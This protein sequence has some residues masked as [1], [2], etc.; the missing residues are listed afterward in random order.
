[1]RTPV[2]TPIQERSLSSLDSGREVSR[3][4]DDLRAM[5]V[6]KIA[7]GSKIAGGSI[8][9]L[10]HEP[11]FPDA[12]YQVAQR[13]TELVDTSGTPSDLRELPQCVSHGN[14]LLLP[15]STNG[16]EY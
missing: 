11:A 3:E 15:V 1:M 2:T 4:R 9:V 14:G 7:R 8:G 16:K 12:G 5:G 13:T 6:F 10:V